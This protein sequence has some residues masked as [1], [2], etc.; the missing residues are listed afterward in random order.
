M[1]LYSEHKSNRILHKHYTKIRQELR[2]FFSALAAAVLSS[3]DVRVFLSSFR[4]VVIS[5]MAFLI[6][7]CW[8]EEY[9][10]LLLKWYSR[11]RLESFRKYRGT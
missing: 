10:S 1:I 11:D 5:Y 3:A 2:G 9:D 8:I 7:L 6:L 4:Q